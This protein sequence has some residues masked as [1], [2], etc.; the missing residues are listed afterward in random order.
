MPALC[1]ARYFNPS[2]GNAKHLAFS[3]F[4]QAQNMIQADNNI[5]GNRFMVRV[6]SLIE[7]D[8]R[9][10]KLL[11]P[12]INLG[13]LLYLKYNIATGFYRKS[14]LEIKF[15]GRQINY[16]TTVDTGT[17]IQCDLF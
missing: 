1:V 16:G 15:I 11:A 9:S 12:S 13:F 4:S 8:G 6:L 10:N 7:T 2:C 5:N 3:F 14:G 17:A